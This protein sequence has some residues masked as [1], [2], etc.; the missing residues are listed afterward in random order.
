MIGIPD[1]VILPPF[2]VTIQLADEVHPPAAVAVTEYVPAKLTVIDEVVWPLFHKKVLKS[3]AFVTSTIP[4]WPPHRL[5]GPTKSATGPPPVMVI[6]S[7]PGQLT[8]STT[9]V[10]FSV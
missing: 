5:V 8:P 2:A 4:D 6:S 10:T 3:L 1:K 9:V 7:V